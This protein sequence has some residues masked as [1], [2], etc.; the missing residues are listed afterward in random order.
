MSCSCFNA[1]GLIC[2]GTCRTLIIC[3]WWFNSSAMTWWKPACGKAITPSCKRLIWGTVVTPLGEQRGRSQEAEGWCWQSPVS[4]WSVF[5]C[6]QWKVKFLLG[7]S[8]LPIPFVD[9]Q[10]WKDRHNAW[11]ALCSDAS[12]G[13]CPGSCVQHHSSSGRDAAW[14]LVSADLRWCHHVC[15][16]ASKKPRKPG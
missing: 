2:C 11:K 1:P 12:R 14:I 7:L 13:F 5:F 15:P 10:G 3:Y 8:D 16:G 4:C 9:L 6:V